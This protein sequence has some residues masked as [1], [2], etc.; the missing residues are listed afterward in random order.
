MN[1]ELTEDTFEPYAMRHYKN[2]CCITIDEF[3]TDLK[4][5]RYIKGLIRRYRESDDLRER[6]ILN[7]IIILGNIFNAEAVVK[8][9]LFK[10]DED[11]WEV[12]KPF[13][14][15]LNFMPKVIYNLNG[16][17]IWASEIR[18]NQQVVHKLTEL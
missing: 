2:D 14:S 10:I 9:L 18:D 15:Y 13:L 6:L 11:D 3:Y 7:H 4:R 5:I 8:M 16:R 12:I 1:L 17:N